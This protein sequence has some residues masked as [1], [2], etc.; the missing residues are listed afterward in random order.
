MPTENHRDEES[1]RDN[2]CGSLF[3]PRP[4]V[5]KKNLV[6]PPYHAPAYLFLF[7]NTFYYEGLILQ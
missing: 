3:P 7:P 2:L 6:T 4:S 1:R 5:A